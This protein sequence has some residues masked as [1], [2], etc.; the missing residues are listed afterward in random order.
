MDT[1]LS[2]LLLHGRLGDLCYPVGIA[3]D[4][5][6]HPRPSWRRAAPAP[7]R[8]PRHQRRAAVGG[9]H[10]ERAARVGLAGVHPSL[11]APRAHHIAR[12]VTLAVLGGAC[13][14]FVPRGEDFH[15]RREQR[16]GHGAAKAL[17]PPA[18]DVGVRALAKHARA[19]PAQQR[20]RARASLAGGEIDAG[21][22]QDQHRNVTARRGGMRVIW[23]HV[24][25]LH[26]GRHRRVEHRLATRAVFPA[27]RRHV[28]SLC[29]RARVAPG[30]AG[31][32]EEVV[33]R[34]SIDL[35]TSLPLGWRSRSC[36]PLCT[37]A[38]GASWPRPAAPNAPDSHL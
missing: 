24:V 20:R 16:V 37:G 7:R 23:V 32:G 35:R 4:A 30:V 31:A 36:Q 26:D 2:A 28:Q 19:G 33:L 11:R 29:A 12:L 5:R 8:E 13:R 22:Q 27:R 3:I 9:Q 10:C 14:S 18:G 15:R 21:R 34:Q 1:A 38:P 25:R 17:A 6:V